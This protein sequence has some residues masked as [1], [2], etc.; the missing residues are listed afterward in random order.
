MLWSVALLVV[1]LL[2]AVSVFLVAG[3]MDNPGGVTSTGPGWQ[4]LR[5]MVRLVRAQGEGRLPGRAV[6]VAHHAVGA[7]TVWVGRR[8]A[9]TASARGQAAPARP[10]RAHRPSERPVDM[11]MDAFFAATIEAKPAYVEPAELTDAL[12]RARVQATRSL[13]VPLGTIARSR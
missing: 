12:Q 11:G 13:H 8:P 2:L 3:A 1:C 6:A 10:A 7:P 4:R 9:Q 5:S